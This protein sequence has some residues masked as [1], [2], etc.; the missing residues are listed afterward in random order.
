MPYLLGE[1]FNGQ[2]LTYI[3]GSRAIFI[4]S[5]GKDNTMDQALK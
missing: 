5:R 2:D 1:E 4:T 3:L